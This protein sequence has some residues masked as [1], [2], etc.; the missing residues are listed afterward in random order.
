MGYGF[1]WLPEGHIR[2]ELQSGLLK[3]LPLQAGS[4][5]EAPLYLILANADCPGRGVKRLADIISE[6]VQPDNFTG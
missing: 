1:A 6:S 3:Q 2:E 4:M 5:R